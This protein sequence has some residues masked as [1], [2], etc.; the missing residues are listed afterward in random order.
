MK[1]FNGIHIQLQKINE[2]NLKQDQLLMGGA[3]GATGATNGSQI[4]ND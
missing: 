3:L 1:D 4:G 2:I